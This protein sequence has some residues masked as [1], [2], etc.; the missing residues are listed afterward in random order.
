VVATG[1]NW[2]GQCNVR[3]WSNIVWVAAGDYHTLGIKSNGTVVAV[4]WNDFA[5]CVVSGWDLD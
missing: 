2:A 1:T 4:G 5:Q 3:N